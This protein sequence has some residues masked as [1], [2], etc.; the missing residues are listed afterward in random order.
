MVGGICNDK[1]AVVTGGGR[2]AATAAARG[3]GGGEGRAGTRRQAGKG[4]L[5]PARRPVWSTQ[6][7]SKRDEGRREG[8]P[9]YTEKRKGGQAAE[10][11]RTNRVCVFFALAPLTHHHRAESQGRTTTST[12]ASS[13]NNNK[14]EARSSSRQPSERVWFR[15][16]LAF[17]F[18]ISGLARHGPTRRK[19][20]ARRPFDRS[21]H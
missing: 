9:P 6:R 3:G 17:C 2:P 1:A 14:K 21:M 4:E 16:L 13:S 7:L 12:S 8:R 20:H 11:R 19:L 18:R 15:F 10:E 5:R